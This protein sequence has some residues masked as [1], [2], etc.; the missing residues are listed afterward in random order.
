MQKKRTLPG[1][2]SRSLP[3]VDVCGA[4]ARFNHRKGTSLRLIPLN[5]SDLLIDM[6][7]WPFSNM[8]LP[9]LGICRGASGLGKRVAWANLY[10]RTTDTAVDISALCEIAER[11][12]LKRGSSS[13]PD[14]Y[15]FSSPEGGFVTG[16]I[17][18]ETCAPGNYYSIELNDSTASAAAAK[19]LAV[20]IAKE[21]F[22]LKEK[23]HFTD[24]SATR[25]EAALLF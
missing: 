23:P 11:L 24:D 14:E 20:K 16:R 3:L 19:Q 15:V 2:E 12:S 6:Q 5:L 9:D 22:A 21:L 7:A 1:R 4:I 17:K 18:L 8:Q 13:N 10:V 25:F